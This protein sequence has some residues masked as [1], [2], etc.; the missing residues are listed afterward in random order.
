MGITHIV[1]QGE[2]LASIAAQY[3]FFDLHTIWDD[4]ANGSC[5]KSLRLVLHFLQPGCPG[6][7]LRLNPRARLSPAFCF[8]GSSSRFL[9]DRK[10]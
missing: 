6:H 1:R 9:N 4:P 3:Q 10:T 5:P 2:H 8:V 7:L